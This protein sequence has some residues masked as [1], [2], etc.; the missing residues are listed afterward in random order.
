MLSCSADNREICA[1]ANGSIRSGIHDRIA[2]DLQE[3]LVC[4]CRRNTVILSSGRQGK[5]YQPNKSVVGARGIGWIQ[6]VPVT[7]SAVSTS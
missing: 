5:G 1:R 2:G 3:H 6:R 7:K 4:G